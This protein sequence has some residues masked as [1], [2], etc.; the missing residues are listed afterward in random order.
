MTKGV[1]SRGS[2]PMTTTGRK[3]RLGINEVRP[4]NPYISTVANAA[5]NASKVL[6]MASGKLPVKLAMVSSKAATSDATSIQTR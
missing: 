4:I 3:K 1:A 6:G 2:Q 5:T